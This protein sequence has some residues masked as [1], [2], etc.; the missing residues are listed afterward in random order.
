MGSLLFLLPPAIAVVLGSG[1]G[2]VSLELG[3]G[4]AL[5]FPQFGEGEMVEGPSQVGVDTKP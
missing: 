3:L 4:Y 1:G 2:V 5:G